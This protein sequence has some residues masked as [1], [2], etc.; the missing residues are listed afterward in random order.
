M[1][2]QLRQIFLDCDGVL[3]DMDEKI[4]SFF[5]MTNAEEVLGKKAF[6]HAIASHKGF[7]EHLRPMPGAFAFVSGVKRLCYMF[8]LPMPIILTGLPQGSWAAPQKQAWRLNNFPDLEMVTCLSRDKRLHMKSV[9]D[10]LID[11]RTGYR[12]LWLETGGVFI[13]HTSHERSLYL[14]EVE[15]EATAFTKGIV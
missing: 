8:G 14:L 4:L 15:L 10:V 2:N 12:D 13:H 7:Y 11:D 1:P 6:W 9:G 3:A 5:G